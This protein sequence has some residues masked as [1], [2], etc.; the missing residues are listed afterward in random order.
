MKEK[1]FRNLEPTMII[2][3][4]TLFL[5]NHPWFPCTEAELGEGAGGGG[6]P[7]FAGNYLLFLITWKKYKLRYLKLNWLLVM[8]LQHTLRKYSR[9]MFNTQSFVIW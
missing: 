4:K 1:I 3:K 8:H 6:C 7:P 2:Y 9:N 5:K